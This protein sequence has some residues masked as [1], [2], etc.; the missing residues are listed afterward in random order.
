VDKKI[1][2]KIEHDYPTKLTGTERLLN[3]CLTFGATKYIAGISGINYM[4][5]ELFERNGVEVIFQNEPS[6]SIFDVI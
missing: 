1:Q 5:L 6:K 4:D 3:I 2:T